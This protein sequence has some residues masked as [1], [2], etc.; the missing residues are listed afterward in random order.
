MHFNTKIK[1]KCQRTQKHDQLRNTTFTRKKK[2]RAP[3]RHLCPQHTHTLNRTNTYA[4]IS[5][6]KLNYCIVHIAVNIHWILLTPKRFADFNDLLASGIF[7]QF[8]FV[9]FNYL[10]TKHFS[11]ISTETHHKHIRNNLFNHLWG[12]KITKINT[13]WYFEQIFF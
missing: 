13:L 7:Q 6:Q 1:V 5:I 12:N 4:W 10:N 3:Q 9:R 8:P 11:R 2:T